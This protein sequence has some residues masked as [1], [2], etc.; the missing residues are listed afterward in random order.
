MKKLKI[1]AVLMVLLCS[2]SLYAKDFDWSEC[3]CNYGGGIQEGDFILNIDG[4]LCYNDL[5]YTAYDDY[6]FIPP[7]M[8]EMQYAQPIWKLPF[9][10]GGYAGFR[11]Y[12]YSYDKWDSSKGK[13]VKKETSY[14]GV[15]FGGEAAYHI[16][17][18]PKG[19]DL[20]AVTRIGGSIP[21]VKP[22]HYWV[23][24]YFHFGEAVGAN[25]F[26]GDTFGLN[27]EFGYPFTKFGVTLKF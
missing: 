11:A 1:F 12:G 9:T 10:F 8:V 18:P 15:F 6:W 22:G 13:Y 16:Q 21:F 3:W 14:W 19:L 4:G 2:T 7:V 20:Y 25:W 24:D 17:M 23:P 5:V 27:L 26:F